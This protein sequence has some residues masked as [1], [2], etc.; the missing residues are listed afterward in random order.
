MA[1]PTIFKLLGFGLFLGADALKTEN[2]KYQAKN[3]AP[4]PELQPTKFGFPEYMR[5]CGY[6]GRR[7]TDEEIIRGNISGSEW[8]IK[9]ATKD[10]EYYEEKIRKCNETGDMQYIDHYKRKLEH[11]KSIKAAYTAEKNKYEQF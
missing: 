1:W 8:M 5:P 2:A 11:A 6:N 7:L 3:I 9:N 10:I 4:R